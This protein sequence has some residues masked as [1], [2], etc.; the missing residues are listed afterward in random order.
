[1]VTNTHVAVLRAA[2]SDD[3]QILDHQREA[4]EFD[5]EPE[6]LSILIAMT[7]I[8]AARIWF[9]PTW[10]GSDVI[11]FV[12]RVRSRDH[13][14]HA[15]IDAQAAEYMLISAL[16]DQPLRGRFDEFAKGYAQV[17]LLAEL[18]RGL[19][20]DQ[21]NVLLEGAREQANGWLTKGGD[22]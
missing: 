5:S 11:H 9:A 17:A 1:M 16:S 15:D 3:A 22:C 21:L 20:S 14:E 12:G 13:G 19:S 2:L 10:S 8:Q 18:T 4:P 7:F 6:D